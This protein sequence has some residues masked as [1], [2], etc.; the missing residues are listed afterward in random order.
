MHHCALTAT[1]LRD[2]EKAFNFLQ[3]RYS[4]PAAATRRLEIWELG[5]WEV[6]DLGIWRSGG[7][8][9]QKFGVKQIKK[10]KTIKIQIRS[11]QNVG[12]VCIS[13]KNSSWPYLGP[14]E[15]IFSMD[16]KNSVNGHQITYF[17]WWANGPYWCGPLLLSTRGGGNS[18]PANSNPLCPGV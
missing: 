15:A 1:A 4:V 18:Y 5:I 6:G 11:A 14:S 7:L 13:K 3:K 2:I 17:P 12:K 9:I 8:E 10:T 16:G